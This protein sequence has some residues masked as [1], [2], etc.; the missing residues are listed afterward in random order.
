MERTLHERA[1]AAIDAIEAELKRLG[2]WSETPPDPSRLV[3]P[4]PFG[5][6][7]LAPEEWLQFVLVPRVREVVRTRGN[8]PSDSQ[9]AVWAVRNF[10]SGAEHLLDLLRD[11]DGLFSKPRPSEG[12]AAPES[13]KPL[14]VAAARSSA[15]L[16]AFLGDPDSHGF[17]DL[18]AGTADQD[19][20]RASAAQAL[21]DGGTNVNDSESH[22]GITPLIVAIAFGNHAVERVLLER[23]AHPDRADAQGRT[24]A[25]WRTRRLTARLRRRLSGLRVVRAAYLTQLFFPNTREFTTPLLAIEVDGPIATDALD[26]MGPNDPFVAMVIGQD[27][28]SRLVRQGKPF[29]M[30]SVAGDSG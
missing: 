5:M 17:D 29:Y 6:N 13:D 7:T 20:E 22:T 3:D 8:F 4:G 28:V 27:A 30:R 16:R 25:D 15:G 1:S 23:G 12:R 26:D 11:F 21:I 14:F 2:S 19:A 9:V 24:P 18:A 10:E